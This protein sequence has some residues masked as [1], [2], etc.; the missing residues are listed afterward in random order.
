MR[1]KVYSKEE[2]LEFTYS[3]LEKPGECCYYQDTDEQLLDE[4]GR[5]ELF[6]HWKELAKELILD[7]P[8]YV[9]TIPA[10]SS[11]KYH[12]ESDLGTGGLIRHMMSVAK[13]ADEIL[14]TRGKLAVTK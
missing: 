11:G 6:E 3:I 9:W 7:M 12:P 4:K 2:Y 13:I 14:R 8:E 5:E 1:Y 10:S